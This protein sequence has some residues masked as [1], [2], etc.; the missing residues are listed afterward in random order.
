MNNRHQ[1]L[2][3]VEYNSIKSNRKIP[4]T[5]ISR[6]VCWQR[7]GKN[8]FKKTNFFVKDNFLMQLVLDNLSNCY[9]CKIRVCLA[10]E[11]EEFCARFK[12]RFSEYI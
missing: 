6:P 11:C 3:W 12:W 2:W 1:H 4:Y 5:E 8:D 9:G 10:N 7:K